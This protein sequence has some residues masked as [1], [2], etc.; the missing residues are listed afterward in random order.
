MYCR[1]RSNYEEGR[2]GIPLTGLP[3][4]HCCACPK[5]GPEFIMSYGVV[6]FIQCVEVRGD[7]LLC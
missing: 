7:C 5:P 1:W 6:L 2:V 3:P 4:P